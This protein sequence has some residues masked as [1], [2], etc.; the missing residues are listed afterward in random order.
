MSQISFDINP[1]TAFRALMDLE[2]CIDDAEGIIGDRLGYVQPFIKDERILAS[3]DTHTLISV[4]RNHFGRSYDA[5]DISQIL[6]D[7]DELD[8]AA[9]RIG[10]VLRAIS[11]QCMPTATLSL[12]EH[13]MVFAVL[14]GN[15]EYIYS[16]VLGGGWDF[17][18]GLI[19][20]VLRHD[21]GDLYDPPLVDEDEQ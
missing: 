3:A 21:F 11:E 4:L 15:E 13:P 2:L 19:D 5:T 1:K 14:S 18:D 12:D 6:S 9:A 10:R 20:D 17:F 16:K 8:G 7:L